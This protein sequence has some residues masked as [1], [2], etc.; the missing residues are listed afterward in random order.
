MDMTHEMDVLGRSEATSKKNRNWKSLIFKSF[1]FGKKEA[2]QKKNMNWKISDF[3]IIQIWKK[4]RIKI[5]IEKSLILK[6][7]F[8]GKRRTS[9]K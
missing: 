6:W 3:Q 2:T 7:M 5:G 1:K 4:R 8:F 9:K